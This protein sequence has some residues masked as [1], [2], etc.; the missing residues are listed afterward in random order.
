LIDADGALLLNPP[1]DGRPS[2]F[3]QEVIFYEGFCFSWFDQ[4]PDA[5]SLFSIIVHMSS[6][7]PFWFRYR[8]LQPPDE[9][10]IFVWLLKKM[11]AKE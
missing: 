8:H 2:G 11:L 10:F 4:L 9:I 1:I 7:P 6:P 5:Q 3:S